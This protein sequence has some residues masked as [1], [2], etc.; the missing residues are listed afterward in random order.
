MSNITAVPAEHNVRR[1]TAEIIPFSFGKRQVRTLLINDQPCF[2]ATDVCEALAIVNT[3]R[4]LSRLDDDEKGTH[5]VSTLGGTQNLSV[6]NESGLYSLILTSRKAEAKIF[7]KWV[8]AEVLP[9]IRKHG[10]YDDHGKMTT[11]MDELIGM[12]ELNVIK[13]L[14]RDKSKAVPADQR[15]GFQLVMHNRLHTRFN[16]PRTELIPAAQFDQACNFIGSYALEGEYIPARTHTGGIHLD[17]FETASLYMLMSRFVTMEKHKSS[18]LAA[19]RALGSSALMD[20]FDQLHDGHI[21]FS[22]LD[23]RRDEI[24]AAYKAT[25]CEGGYVWRAAA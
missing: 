21:S 1:Q 24:Y 9:A 18:M 17:Q 10:R 20:F 7:K 8:T 13:G 2:V 22:V 3:A 15:Q 19:S 14:I 11:L 5:A 16:V 6:V 25:G 23:K 4:A 12:S